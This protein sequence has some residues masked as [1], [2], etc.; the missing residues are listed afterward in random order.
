MAT[1]PATRQRGPDSPKAL[2]R[3]SQPGVYRRGHRFV[4]V[5]RREG[6]QRKESA[7]SFAAARAIKRSRDTEARAD[8]L[9]PFL[10]AYVLAWIDDYAA[11]GFGTF[12]EATR[13][14]Y[15]RLL[16]SYALTYFPVEIRTA[17]LDRAGL[18]GFIS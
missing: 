7:A 11:S 17:E 4:A 13:I 1:G 3:T 6:R 16:I 14:E 8:R 15:R 12:S 18:Q 10:D 9:G 5:Y 2:Q